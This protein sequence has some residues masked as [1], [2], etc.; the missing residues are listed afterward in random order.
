MVSAY[1]DSLPDSAKAAEISRY[2]PHME[3][4]YSWWET[5]RS[6]KIGDYS[7][8]HY[9]SPVNM[10]R[11]EAYMNDFNVLQKLASAE[12]KQILSS[13]ITSAAESGWD[14]SSRWTGSKYVGEPEDL[15]SE[16]ITT[17]IVP[18]DLNFLL[19]WTSLVDGLDPNMSGNL[20][21]SCL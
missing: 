16:M 17:D 9:N 20:K 3:T 6:I 5:N 18:V 21:I 2:L 19:A 7:L 15:L 10:P 13:H 11:P 8:F 14:F 12:D 4:E 1:I